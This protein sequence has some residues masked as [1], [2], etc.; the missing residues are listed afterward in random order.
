MFDQLVGQRMRPN[1]DEAM[2]ASRLDRRALLVCT[3]LAVECR[4][5]IPPNIAVSILKQDGVSAFSE[6]EFSGDW[7]R[8]ARKSEAN[9]AFRIPIAP[10]VRQRLPKS[11]TFWRT[12]VIGI[13]LLWYYLVTTIFCLARRVRQVA[14]DPL[15]E[16][17]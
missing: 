11:C 8:Y 10:I 9:L 13:K 16:S 15:D 14:A 5:P 17:R 12:L 7:D 2:M 4:P 1:L 6:T 3:T